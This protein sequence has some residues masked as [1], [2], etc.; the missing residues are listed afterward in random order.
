V[1]ETATGVFPILL[2]SVQLHTF[3]NQM[4]ELVDSDL[5]LASDQMLPLGSGDGNIVTGRYRID[6]PKAKAVLQFDHNAGN[7]ELFN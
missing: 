5:I 1:D 6:E 7:L 4:W 3:E 2:P